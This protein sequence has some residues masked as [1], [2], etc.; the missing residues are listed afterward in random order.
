MKIV[1]KGYNFTIYVDGTKYLEVYN[2]NYESGSVGLRS[3]KAEAH[4]YYMYIM[5][6]KL[7]NPD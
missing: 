5:D 7:Y 6:L 4:F 3:H 2:E 1:I